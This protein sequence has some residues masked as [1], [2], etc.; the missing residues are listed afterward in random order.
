MDTIVYVRYNKIWVN[1]EKSRAA[2]HI[3]TNPDAIRDG[4]VQAGTVHVQCF[5]QG[6]DFQI[7]RVDICETDIE[8]AMPM[9]LV[10]S[11]FPALRRRRRQKGRDRLTAQIKEELAP[12]LDKWG[13]N[14][15]MYGKGLT[16]AGQTEESAASWVQEALGIPKFDAYGEF[17]WIGRLLPWAEHTHFLVLGTTGCIAR[18]FEK[19]APRAKSLLWI[20]PDHTYRGQAE[21]IAE[22][23][24]QEYGL[25]IDLRFLP[26]GASFARIQIDGK[27]LAE[28]MNVL[29]FTGEKYVPPLQLVPDSVWLDMAA[30]EEKE[31]RILSRR[32]RV[33]YVSLRTVA[34]G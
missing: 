31:K 20:V 19:L 2:R 34:G 6:Q 13:E 1:T 15:C 21:A 12:F 25:P 24:Y 28:T 26:E 22:E 11:C 23:I 17:K 29:D 33:R 10:E 5:P 32:M 9:R 16:D 30:M 4:A 3:G 18:V 27:Y 8:P 7:L 14:A